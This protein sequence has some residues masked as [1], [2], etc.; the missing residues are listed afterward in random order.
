V[1][2]ALALDH[3]EIKRKGLAFVGM[4]GGQFL[5]PHMGHV[6][7]LVRLKGSAKPPRTVGV[8]AE[9]L[10]DTLEGICGYNQ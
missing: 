5:F 3:I 9:D 10:G 8:A 6:N 2:E 4:D 7:Q 1:G